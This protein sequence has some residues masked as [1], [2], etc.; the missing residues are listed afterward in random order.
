MQYTTNL[1]NKHTLRLKYIIGCLLLERGKHSFIRSIPQ[2]SRILDVGCG[3]NWPYICKTIRPDCYYI[4]IDVSDYNQKNEPASISD[5]Y[6]LANEHS[7]DEDIRQFGN[8][9]DAVISSHNI[10]HCIKPEN[11]LRAM[12]HVLKKDGIIYLSFPCAASVHFPKRKKTLNFYT[13]SSHKTPPDPNSIIKILIDE[14]FTV[15]YFSPRYR[16]VMPA[17]IGLLFEPIAALCKT[18]FLGTWALY[19]F[20]TVIWSRK[21]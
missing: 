21:N 10:E 19:G 9:I 14:G 5:E 13:D 1:L 7:F 18:A 8:S 3:N 6:I 4:G 15:E 17:I 20:E 16:P 12:L 2:A 11:V